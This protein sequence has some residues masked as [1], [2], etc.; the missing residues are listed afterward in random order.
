M[1]GEGPIVYSKGLEPWPELLLTTEGLYHVGARDETESI[2]VCAV[3][4]PD[5][6]RS[7]RD[8]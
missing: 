4:N 6:G 7:S 3:R 8:S 1:Q 2:V 5:V